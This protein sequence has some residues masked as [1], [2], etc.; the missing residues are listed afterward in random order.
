MTRYAPLDRVSV[1]AYHFDN[2]AEGAA[3]WSHEKF[4]SKWRTA[5]VTGQLESYDTVHTH[6]LVVFDEKD[7]LETH[8]FKHNQLQLVSRCV[9]TVP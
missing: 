3:R 5:R 9:K 1:N 2:P 4:G 6:W 8:K 7:I